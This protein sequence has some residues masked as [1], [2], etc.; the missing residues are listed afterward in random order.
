MLKN[1]RKWDVKTP[2]APK[3]ARIMH[4]NNHDRCHCCPCCT[5]LQ[6]PVQR[7][8][9]TS[10]P[11]TTVLPC[12]VLHG[13]W[14]SRASALHY[15]NPTQQLRMFFKSYRFEGQERSSVST[16]FNFQRLKQSAA[17]RWVGTWSRQTLQQVLP[18]LGFVYHGNL[19]ARD[20]EKI[21]A[22]DFLR[23]VLYQQIATAAKCKHIEVMY[24]FNFS[25]T[26]IKLLMPV[27]LRDCGQDWLSYSV[28]RS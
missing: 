10:S 20:L 23:A 18:G 11:W 3:S 14:H 5:N 28:C 25:A 7:N 6:K 24:L 2:W 12:L 15:F 16:E 8:A 9:L 13:L 21:D 26:K 19:G 1:H 4:D 27:L 17:C 22:R